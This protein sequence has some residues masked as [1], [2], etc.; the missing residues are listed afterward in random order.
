MLHKYGYK[1]T[2]RAIAVGTIILTATLL[3]FV[4]R[5]LPASHSA[6][7]VKTDWAF[8]RKPIFW[9]YM[10]S[11]ITQSLGFY[12]P[13]LYLPTYA[14]AIGLSPR[15]G[16]VLLAVMNV[17]SVTGQ[18]TY[19]S[20]S[21]SRLPLNILLISTTTV[22]AIASLAVWGFAKSLAVL[23]VFVLIYGFFAYAYMAMRV[24]MG[25]AVASEQSDAL[26]IFCLFSFAQGISN[27]L[28]GPISGGLLD[29][30][31]DVQE[32]GYNRY[33]ALVIFTG[34]SMVA[35]TAFTGLSYVAPSKIK[36]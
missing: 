33:K 29:P 24:R 8:V 15:T 6:A 32:Y 19:G 34:L 36:H 21:D 5:R 27:V 28:A 22:A 2:L 12:L 14:S 11:T 26:T 4:K 1:T 9:L 17:A 20:L 23:V 7:L 30:V 13:S 3:P 31:T 10:L 18:F 35:S 25:T 16:A